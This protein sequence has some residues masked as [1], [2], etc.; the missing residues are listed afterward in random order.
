MSIFGNSAVYFDE[1]QK[2]LKLS[3]KIRFWLRFRQV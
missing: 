2:N 1:E 3:F